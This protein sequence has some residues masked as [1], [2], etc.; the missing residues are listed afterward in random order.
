MSDVDSLS[1]MARALRESRTGQHPAPDETREAVITEAAS[2]RRRRRI[3]VVWL[4]PLAA[5]LVFSTAVASVGS[6]RRT[7]W[8]R[9]LQQ[10][11]RGDR[12]ATPV[13]AAVVPATTVVEPTASDDV[14]AVIEE[15]PALANEPEAPPRAL[16]VANMAKRSTKPVPTVHE[17]P[18]APTVNAQPTNAPPAAAAAAVEDVDGRLYARAHEAHFVQHNTAA[19]LTA[20]DAYLAAE[21]DGRFALEA[22]YNRALCLVRLDRLDEAK[23]SLRPFS[24]GRYGSYRQVEAT[25]LLDALNRR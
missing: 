8:Q 24:D 6:G 22:K 20:W 14:A 1:R 23:A 3:G 7:A 16:P 17:A 11:L 21:P 25:R 10:W 12:D 15:Q 18:A 9:Y 19:A 5:V 13:A 2:K 4:V